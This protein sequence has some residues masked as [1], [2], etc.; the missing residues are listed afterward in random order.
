MERISSPMARLRWSVIAIAAVATSCT[1]ATARKNASQTPGSE[2][3]GDALRAEKDLVASMCLAGD[4]RQH[5]VYDA[6]EFYPWVTVG[7]LYGILSPRPRGPA[8]GP[9]AVSSSPGGHAYAA[10]FGNGE[11]PICLTGAPKEV[12][13]AFLSRQFRGK[14]PGVQS[15]GQIG[16]FLSAVILPRGTVVGDQKL[17]DD[18]TKSHSWTRGGGRETD[19]AAFEKLCTGVRGSEV[20]NEWRIQFNAFLPD[21][22]VDLVTA[23]GGSVPLSITTITVEEVKPA[24]EFYYPIEGTRGPPPNSRPEAALARRR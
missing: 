2:L 10:A 23:S 3:Q 20:G 5:K 6:R 22:G 18:Q 16:H 19:T 24:G 9:D 11:T 15:I 8:F 4:G 1:G 14:F 17:L 12:L 21:G 13:S 7:R